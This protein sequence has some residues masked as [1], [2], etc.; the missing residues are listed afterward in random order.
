MLPSYSIVSPVR[1]EAPYLP[2]TA[3]SLLHQH[4]PPRAWVIV[5]DGSTDATPEIARELAREHAWIQL[6][7]SGGHGP[8][9]RGGRVVHAFDTGLAALGQQTELVV[10]LDGDVH[11][12]AHYFAW[13]AALFASDPRAGI[14]GGT[15]IVHDGRRWRADHRS[16]HTVPGVAKAYRASCLEEIGGLRPAMGWDGIDEYG[17]RA[18]GWHVH[19]LHELPILHYKRRGAAQRWYRARW[20]E[21]VAAHYMGY[22]S[23]FVALRTAYRMARERP[24][25]AG[26]ITLGLGFAWNRA[27]RRPQVDDQLARAE[28]RREQSARLRAL[29][30]GATPPSLPQPCDGGP[31]FWALPPHAPNN[32]RHDETRPP[33][34]RAETSSRSSEA[35]RVLASSASAWRLNGNAPS[36]ERSSPPS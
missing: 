17:A 34:E 24:R 18:R 1:D 14:V 3:A 23:S 6:V 35:P 36:A 4:H 16:L 7:Q 28:L 10:K 32:S 29:L 19:V 12:P 8:R 9:A 15:S 20:E 13:V 33:R 5:D 21:G 26:G 31:A 30:R 22:R 2:R 27:R 11:L 25:V